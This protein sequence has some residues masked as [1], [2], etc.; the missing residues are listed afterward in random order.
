VRVAPL[1]PAAAA[2][3]AGDA[4][5]VSLRGRVVPRFAA[6]GLSRGAVA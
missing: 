2:A 6:A 4:R 3:L 5:R 1:A